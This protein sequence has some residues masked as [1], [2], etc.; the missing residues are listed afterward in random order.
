[1]ELHLKECKTGS[2]GIW[3]QLQRELNLWYCSLG[4]FTWE[5]AKKLARCLYRYFLV[6]RIMFKELL[7]NLVW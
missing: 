2:E 4:F 1:M 3:L 7:V 6:S 5:L